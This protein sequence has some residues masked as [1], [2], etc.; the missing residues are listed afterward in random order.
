MKRVDHFN[1]DRRMHISVFYDSAAA[2]PARSPSG[3]KRVGR[4]KEYVQGF[5]ILPASGMHIC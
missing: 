1:V 2:A 5:T 4:K 3:L